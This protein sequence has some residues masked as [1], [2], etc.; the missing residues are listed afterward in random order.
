MDSTNLESRFY[1]KHI[2]NHLD[3]LQ[4][5]SHSIFEPLPSTSRQ[6]HQ[7]KALRLG[8]AT[9]KELWLRIPFGRHK[10][11]YYKPQDSKDRL[12]PLNK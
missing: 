6:K 3:K 8:Q 2:K 10:V 11:C 4:A 12:I 1:F 5:P 7:M 9:Q